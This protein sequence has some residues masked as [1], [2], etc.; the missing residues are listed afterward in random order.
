MIEQVGQERQARSKIHDEHPPDAPKQA[1]FA[2][3]EFAA[4]GYSHAS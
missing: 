2:D 3:V 4:R 1:S